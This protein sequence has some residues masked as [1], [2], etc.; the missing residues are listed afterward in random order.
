MSA[1]PEVKPVTGLPELSVSRTR[2]SGTSYLAG[3][4]IA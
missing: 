4:I 2:M 1:S 3:G